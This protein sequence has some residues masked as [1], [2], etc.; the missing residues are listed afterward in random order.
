MT[1]IDIV[2]QH[3]IIRETIGYDGIK[4]VDIIDLPEVLRFL[5]I[6]HN[7]IKIKNID[8]K[9]DMIADIIKTLSDTELVA[10]SKEVIN[11]AVANLTIYK[12]LMGKRNDYDDTIDTK[13]FTNLSS[14]V[15]NELANRLLE[16]DIK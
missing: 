3:I 16:R 6:V 12:Q 1:D 13:D 15:I 9:K 14:I 11:P 4:D 7:Y 2:D 8:N 10:I 5:K